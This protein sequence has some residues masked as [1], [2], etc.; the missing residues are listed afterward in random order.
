MERE[1]SFRGKRKGSNFWILFQLNVELMNQDEPSEFLQYPLQIATV[2]QGS[3]IYDK[4]NTH[5]FENDYVTVGDK[6]MLVIFKNGCFYTPWKKSNYRLGGWKK[7]TIE[8]VGNK[9]DNP[10]LADSIY[11]PK[12]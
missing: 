8:I 1:V 6:I 4:N 11:F 7:D 2:G 9:I 12:K 5:I 3:G 10:E